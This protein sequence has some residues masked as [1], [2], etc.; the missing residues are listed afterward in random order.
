[1]ITSHSDIIWLFGSCLN[2]SISINSAKWKNYNPWRDLILHFGRENYEG[3]PWKDFILYWVTPV[4]PMKLFDFRQMNSSEAEQAL[5]MHHILVVQKQLWCQ[6]LSTMTMIWRKRFRAMVALM[7]PWSASRKETMIRVATADPLWK[8]QSTHSLS[9]PGGR[10]THSSHDGLSH[11]PVWTDMDAYR[12]IR[13]P[14]DEDEGARWAYVRG[15]ES[16]ANGW[17]KSRTRL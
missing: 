12:V 15:W 14:G 16:R 10:T 17:R 3:N 9:V 8:M 11:A 1:M 4:L 5:K 13:H 2:T 7:R 6:K